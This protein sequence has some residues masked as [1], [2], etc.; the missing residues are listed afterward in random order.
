MVICKCGRYSTRA[1]ECRIC[2]ARKRDLKFKAKKRLKD[3]KIKARQMAKASS[4]N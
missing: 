1:L 4:G 3:A 2:K